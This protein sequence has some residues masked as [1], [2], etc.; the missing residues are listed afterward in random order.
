ML[1]WGYI[2]VGFLFVGKPVM[3]AEIEILD[4]K[5]GC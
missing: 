3:D 4:L 5:I 2:F 1:I